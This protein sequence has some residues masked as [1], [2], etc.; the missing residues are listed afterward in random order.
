MEYPMRVYGPNIFESYLSL[1]LNIMSLT[2]ILF[3]IATIFFF[4]K[5]F[6]VNYLL[7]GVLISAIFLSSIMM[8]LASAGI[9]QNRAILDPSMGYFLLIGI[10]WV[11]MGIYYSNIYFVI[12]GAVILLFLLF[13]NLLRRQAIKT[14]FKP[15]F[16]SQRQ[17]ETII[18][19]ADAMMDGDGKEALSPIEIAVNVDHMFSTISSPA[20]KQIKL[21]M[22]L[23]EWVLP[24]LRFR[25]FP[26]SNLGSIERRCLIEKVIGSKGIFRNVAKALKMLICV[27]Y[28]G[29]PKGMAQT[30]Y[31]PFDD[32]ENSQNKVQTPLI[33]KD[34][35]INIEF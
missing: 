24:L 25:P 35:F 23:V 17:F 18:Q 6:S 33:H 29:D 8:G 21:V 10:A 5:M 19:I 15:R 11:I 27:G 1:W 31:V 34:P 14:R 9:R 16:F 3:S 28:Y 20:V 12:I 4:Q 13:I 26:F 32:R 2:G 7:A 22:I 30:G